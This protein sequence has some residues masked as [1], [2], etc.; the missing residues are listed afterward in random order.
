MGKQR[1]DQLLVD[2]GL[3]G[4]RAEAQRLI[5]AGR[6][7]QAVDCPVRKPGQML[8]AD[9]GMQ[10]SAGDDYASRGAYKLLAALDAFKPELTDA[11]ALDVGASTGGFTDLLLRR[12]ARR[13]YAV[14][15]GYGQLHYRLRQDSRVVCLEKVNAREIPAALIPDPIDVLT[16]DVSFISLT[17]VLPACKPFLH[18]GAWVFVLVK[19]QFEAERSEVSRGGV[20]RAEAVRQR[21]V[22]KIAAFGVADLGWQRVGVVPSP[23][24]GPKGNQEYMVAFRA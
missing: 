1:A 6:V 10:V 2:R 7:L 5:M 9:A 13:V 8:D 11:V 22:E 17:K 12:G 23:I 16:A 21:C 19:P 3:A 20:V 24:T 14:D 4:T 15:V 18:S